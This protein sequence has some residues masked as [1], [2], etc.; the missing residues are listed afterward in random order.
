MPSAT[1]ADRSD[2]MAPSN[3][4]VIAGDSSVGINET[5]KAGIAKWGRPLGMPPKRL[6][7]GEPSTSDAP[8]SVHRAHYGVLRRSSRRSRAKFSQIAFFSFRTG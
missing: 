5:W 1:T 8:Y 6:P 7:I 3:P 4:T 2:S